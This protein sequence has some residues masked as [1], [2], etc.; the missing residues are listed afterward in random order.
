ML[1]IIN[2]QQGSEEW[3]Q[4]RLGKATSSKFAEI[5]AGGK[6]LTRRSYLC[7]LIGERITGDVA[8]SYQ[9]SEMRWGV[10]HEPQARAMYS[11]ERDVDVFVFYSW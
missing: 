7:Q 9:S 8:E 3:F 6:G 1:E 2:C 10:Q 5:M 4:A 11:L